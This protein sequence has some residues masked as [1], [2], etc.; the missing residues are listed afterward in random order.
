LT[1]TTGILAAI[2][3]ESGVSTMFSSG[4]VEMMHAGFEA[5]A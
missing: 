5:A 3:L 1:I 4:T 2:A